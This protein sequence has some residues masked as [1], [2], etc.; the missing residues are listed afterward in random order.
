MDSEPPK[1]PCRDP[2]TG[3]KRVHADLTPGSSASGGERKKPRSDLSQGSPHPQGAVLGQELQAPLDLHSCPLC[4]TLLLR[5]DSCQG[6]PCGHDFCFACIR[7]HIIRDSRCPSCGQDLVR[8]LYPKELTE[9]KVNRRRPEEDKDDAPADVDAVDKAH[10]QLA[11]PER[12]DAHQRGEQLHIAGDPTSA[13]GVPQQEC[14]GTPSTPAAQAA[15]AGSVVASLA[16]LAAQGPETPPR[17][18]AA[19]SSPFS[20]SVPHRPSIFAPKDVA[21]TSQLVAEDADGSSPLAA[22]AA[23]PSDASANDVSRSALLA[24]KDAAGSSQHGAGGSS[25]RTAV[26]NVVGASPPPPSAPGSANSQLTPPP[27][28]AAPPAPM[29]A[30]MEGSRNTVAAGGG[31]QMARK[32]EAR[33]RPPVAGVQAQGALAAAPA[34]PLRGPL[35]PPAAKTPAQGTPLLAPPA[36]PAVVAP[37]P[38]PKAAAQYIAPAAAAAPPPAPKAAAQLVADVTG[39]HIAPFD[40]KHEAKRRSKA[41]AGPDAEG[42]KFRDSLHADNKELHCLFLDCSATRKKP[43]GI[44]SH[45]RSEHTALAMRLTKQQCDLLGIQVLFCKD[46]KLPFASGTHTRKGCKGLTPAQARAAGLAPAAAV[47]VPAPQ[48]GAAPPRSAA[49]EQAE[50]LDVKLPR[51]EDIGNHGRLHNKLPVGA[52]AAF[53]AAASTVFADYVTASTSG[54][55]GAHARAITNILSLPGLVAVKSDRGGRRKHTNTVLRNC[56]QIQAA[57]A[58]A[59]PGQALRPRGAEPHKPKEGDEAKRRALRAQAHLRDLETARAARALLADK[60]LDTSDHHVLQ[61]LRDKHPQG[62]PP[63]DL[64]RMPAEPRVHTVVDPDGKP[65]QD[66][67]KRLRNGSAAGPSGWSIHLIDAAMLH[68]GNKRAIC[69]FLEDIC[70]GN[71]PAAVRPHLLSSS[72]VALSKSGGGIRPIAVNEIFYRL[73]AAYALARVSE[74]AVAALAPIQQGVGIPNGVENTKHVLERMLAQGKPRWGLKV[75]FANAYN[76]VSRTKAFQAVFSDPRFAP[77][78]HIFDMAYHEASPL[79]TFDTDGRRVHVLSSSQGVRQGD[80]LSALVFAL[81]LHPHIKNALAVSPSSDALAILDDV[82]FWDTDLRNLVKIAD[83]LKGAEADGLVWQPV[84]SEIVGLHDE[85]IPPEVQ[86]WLD[87]TGIPV[88][89]HSTEIL[90]NLIS[91]D[92]TGETQTQAILSK[93]RKY[94]SWF[95]ALLSSVLTPQEVLHLALV[96]GVPIANYLLRTNAPKHSSVGALWLTRKL[97]SV[98]LKALGIDLGE[99]TADQIAQ[100]SLPAKL[101]GLGLLNFQTIASAA[102]IGSQVAAQPLIEAKVP[103]DERNSPAFTELWNHAHKMLRDSSPGNAKLQRLLPDNGNN[104]PLPPAESKESKAP[105][106]LQHALSEAVHKHTLQGLLN[107]AQPADRARLLSASA[108]GGAYFVVARPG[109]PHCAMSPMATNL[110]IRYRLGLPPVNAPLRTGGICPLCGLMNV[111]AWHGLDCPQL[112]RRDLLAR[113]DSVINILYAAARAIGCSATKEPRIHLE[114]RKTPDLRML[115]PKGYVYVDG[116]ITNCCAPS[117]IAKAQRQLGATDEAE[118]R[119]HDKY[120]QEIKR[121]NGKF[122]AFNLETFGAFGK[123]ATQVISLLQRAYRPEFA[124]MT[125]AQARR[126]LT[127]GVACAVQTGNANAMERW[128]HEAKLVKEPVFDRPAA[129]DQGA[130]SRVVTWE[131]EVADVD[132]E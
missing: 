63:A 123:D 90:G 58:A 15:H 70:N 103:A 74:A 37:P 71:I 46:C 16:S 87:R 6:F 9:I 65:L 66:A 109:D 113:H 110:A 49:Q 59:K 131:E 25:P 98:V 35:T 27:L 105:A 5:D 4:R 41:E 127:H 95:E 68:P 75:D 76:A 8:L 108:K 104:N 121:Q 2:I 11:E 128:L 61:S 34:K 114:N 118:K 33:N 119:K 50:L 21:G 55:V 83:S 45:L 125:W 39:D 52:E 94:E 44:L 115:L 84:K 64:P 124:T 3:K 80:P 56:D 96:C 100:L 10:A 73:A 129:E 97:R 57:L 91:R 112:K 117:H 77:I 88:A 62:P 32:S 93:L 13:H 47:Q 24:L 78:W 38:A 120:E 54:D 17:R 122:L 22:I 28:R 99:L 92:K 72:L 43:S 107:R 106:K 40:P 130:Y 19:S 14:R 12:K 86:T 31:K 81:T 89:R 79:L 29:S 101:G 60:P 1:D 26:G 132:K 48:H 7:G 23:C 18:T 85:P 126:V 69:R 111:G 20:A 67:L 82:T 116:V 36:A 53:G 102:W 42:P 51:P 30:D